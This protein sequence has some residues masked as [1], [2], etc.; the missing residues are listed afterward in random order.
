MVKAKKKNKVLL[1]TGILSWD[2]VERVTDRY[3]TVKLF[4]SIDQDSATAFDINLSGKKGELI[5]EVIETRKSNH[6]GDLF[7]GISPTVPKVGDVLLLG[8]GKVFFEGIF[9]VGVQPVRKRETLWMDIKNLYR[10]QFQTVKLFF[11]EI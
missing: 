8:K 2:R 7:H 9:A 5:A 6:I 10:A 1:G 3:G 4:N 11:K